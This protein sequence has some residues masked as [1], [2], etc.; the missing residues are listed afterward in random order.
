VPGPDAIA[1]KTLLDLIEVEREQSTSMREVAGSLRDLSDIATE[2][3]NRSKWTL[4]LLVATTAL[5]LAA[6]IVAVIAL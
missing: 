1:A 6:L 3:S 4:M 2:E 5:S